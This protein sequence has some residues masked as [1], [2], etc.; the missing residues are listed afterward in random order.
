MTPKKIA[1]ILANHKK[2]V[3]SQEGG[4]RADLQ[5]ADLR[6]ADLRGADLQRADLRGADLQGADL[7]GADLRGAEIENDGMLKTA[8]TQ[9]IGS[10]HPVLIFMRTHL[11]IGCVCKPVEWWLENNVR[12]G[13]ENQYTSEQITEYRRY[14]EL[15]DAMTRDEIPMETAAAKPQRPA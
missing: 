13:E 1:A 15:A 10:A 3:I 11:K 12:C 4:Q 6:G 14:I 8:P 5:G 2:W 9:I 7:Q